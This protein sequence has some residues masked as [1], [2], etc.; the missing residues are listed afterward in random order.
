MPKKIEYNHHWTEEEDR[1]LEADFAEVYT[2]SLKEVLDRFDG[3]TWF[4]NAGDAAT[5]E[6][7]DDHKVTLTW[8]RQRQRADLIQ[9]AKAKGFRLVSYG[10]GGMRFSFYNP[11]MANLLRVSIEKR[12]PCPACEPL[13]LEEAEALAWDELID[14]IGP[15]KL[16]RLIDK[17]KVIEECQ[18]P[19]PALLAKM[20]EHAGKDL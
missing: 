6:F 8:K 20:A 11:H 7:G 2:A 9:E 17:E 5:I 10:R 1:R 13:T 18:G 19:P 12:M 14:W 4:V 15:D 3:L 16:R